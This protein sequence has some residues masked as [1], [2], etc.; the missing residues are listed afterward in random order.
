MFIRACH[1]T[2][3]IC[4]EYLNLNKKNDFKYYKFCYNIK[5][6]NIEN[7]CKC[8]DYHFNNKKIKDVYK[9]KN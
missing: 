2:R 5:E 7:I 9:I 3:C 8:I 1:K 4:I 6:K